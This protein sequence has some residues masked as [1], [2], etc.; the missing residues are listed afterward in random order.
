MGLQRFKENLAKSLVQSKGAMKED[1]AN[2]EMSELL[3][4]FS[5]HSAFK[6]SEGVPKGKGGK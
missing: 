6:I 4:S 5:E 3:N 2:L 1:A